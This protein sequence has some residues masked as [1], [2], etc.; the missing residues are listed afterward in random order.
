MFCRRPGF[1][2]CGG[3]Q[4]RA[5]GDHRS[6][7]KPLVFQVQQESPHVSGI[8]FGDQSASDW[9]VSNWIA[10][11]QHNTL[12]EMNFID[13]KFS[14][15]LG[16]QRGPV[17]FS[18]R[19]CQAVVQKTGRELQVKVTPHGR[20]NRSGVE[21]VNQDAVND[22]LSNLVVVARLGLDI[23]RVRAEGLTTLAPGRIFAV[24]DLSPDLLLKCNRPHT[25]NQDPLAPIQSAT[26]RTSSLSRT[27]RFPYCFAGCFLESMP[28]SFVL[29][30]QK[31]QS[32]AIRH[33]H[34]HPNSNPV[35]ISEKCQKSF[36]I[37]LRAPR[38][39]SFLPLLNS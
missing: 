2:D 23:L 37:F 1:G 14:E 31:T 33:F 17:V 36:P 32:K 15:H 20:L 9:V 4:I 38:L 6:R 5:I 22:C 26:R 7:R 29:S 27:T 39:S 16:S 13:A 3:I 25:T 11:E 12:A 10:G 18:D 24:M 30:P 21:L 8:V 28:D 19:P 35:E 34:V